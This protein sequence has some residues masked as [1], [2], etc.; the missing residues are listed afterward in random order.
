MPFHHV[1][2]KSKS[3]KKLVQKKSIYRFSMGCSQPIYKV[4]SSLF[5][6]KTNLSFHL[7]LLKKS[8]LFSSRPRLAPLRRMFKQ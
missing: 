1:A 6:E 8:Q 5:Q 7:W 2:L 3:F 4:I